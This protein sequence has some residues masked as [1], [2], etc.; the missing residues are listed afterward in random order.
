MDH[1]DAARQHFEQ[2]GP[3]FRRDIARADRADRG[4]SRAR[5]GWTFPWVS[6]GDDDFNH[7]FRVSFTP[8]DRAAG[9]AIYNYGKTVIRK[10]PDMFGSVSS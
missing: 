7:D 5:L 3:G 4:P 2:G 8:E 10:A 6:S 9:R 1:V